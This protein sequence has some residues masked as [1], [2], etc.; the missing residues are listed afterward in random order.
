MNTDDLIDSKKNEVFCM[1]P[2]T[3]MHFW[4]DGRTMPCCITDPNTNVL[5]NF[6]DQTIAQ[7][8]NSELIR[9]MRRNMLAGRRSHACSKCYEQESA[10]V[11]TLRI[12]SNAELKQHL[13][14]VSETADDGA[15][16]RVN[17]AYLDIRFSNIC[18][19]RCRTCGHG[20]SS[21]WYDEYKA[22]WPEYSQ[23]RIMN[24]NKSGDFWAQLLPH[25]D[26]TEHV[27]FAGGESLM[28]DEH[29]RMLDHWISRGLKY[30]LLRYTTNFTVLNYK[31][32]DLFELWKNFNNI[33]VAA[34]LDGSHAR[35]E[36][37][38]K[39]MVWSEVVENRRRLMREVP[40]VVFAITPTVSLMN[41]L[42]LPDFHRE[43]IE[44]GLLEPQHA[45]LNILTWPNHSSVRVLPSHLKDQARH[46]IREHQTWL[47]SLGTPDWYVSNWDSVINVMDSSDDSHLI[48]DFLRET[49]LVDG[50]RK[51]SFFDTFP[52]LASMDPDARPR[53]V[54]AA[55]VPSA[56]TTG[57]QLDRIDWSG[58]PVLFITW[59]TS[60]VCNHRC[61]YCNPG[62]YG[63]T[64]PNTDIK[65]YQRNMATMLA[66]MRDRGFKRIKLFLSG[67]E[68]TH[69]QGLIPMLDWFK[70]SSD[71]DVTVA[72]NTNLS[73]PT[74]WWERFH[75]YFD[76]VVASYHPEWVK[77][78]QFMAN[79]KYLET[80]VNY[81]AIRMMMAE[82]HWDS[83]M[84]RAD[85][86]FDAM[87]NVH[88]EYV[89]ILAEMS[90]AAQPYDYSDKNKIDWLMNNNLRIK[91]TLT[92][93]KNRVGSTATMEHWSDGTVQP[94]N[95]NRLAAERVNFFEGWQCD[96]GT[97][98][99]IGINGDITL[100]SC[101]VSG[102]IGNISGQ[103][104]LDSL[105]VTV[106]CSKHHCHCGTDIC[107]PKRRT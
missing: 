62:N 63:G 92:K 9:D 20:L 84:A 78:E 30:V 79:A 93:P 96:L 97:S 90:T 16:P 59:Q 65:A 11:E 86:I 2:W 72:I 37:L 23:P 80:R 67:G 102:V 4:P 34:S 71:Y 57:A 17:L 18:N 48:P 15:L 77:H 100:G 95:S 49:K 46:K 12:S 101:G 22:R 14:L 19:L 50:M 89:P 94:V 3:H 38:R 54:P 35:G 105:P 104:N 44:L 107:I 10:G 27:H 6:N 26:H 40:K 76:D 29:Y 70:F 52:E 53:S 1:L 58:E 45:R 87:G 106:T 66:A 61:G 36:Y 91:Q 56:V 28:T 75:S 85:E 73:R 60:D 25:L 64:Q 99:N 98:I 42:H 81:L 47:R 51:E 5:G 82:D 69:W 31:K 83:Q 103:L 55:A 7:L 41:V 13:P 33:R 43:W 68:P 32:R 74:V 88:M 8:W 21:G 24:I 39:N